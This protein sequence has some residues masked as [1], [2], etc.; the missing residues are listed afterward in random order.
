MHFSLW[1]KKKNKQTENTF[2]FDVHSL[3]LANLV[4]LTG[5]NGALVITLSIDLNLWNYKSSIQ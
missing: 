2:A 3:P 5:F 4:D 1:K